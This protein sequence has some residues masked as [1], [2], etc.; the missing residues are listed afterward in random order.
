[1]GGQH[2]LDRQLEQRPEVF[3]HLLARYTVLQ[4]LSRDLEAAAEVDQGV[5]GND[6]THTLDS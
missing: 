3:D 4:H 6:R 5:A 1:V 2:D